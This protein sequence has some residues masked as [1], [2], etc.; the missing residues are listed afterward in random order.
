MTSAFCVTDDTELQ[1][2]PVD[3]ECEV[4]QTTPDDARLAAITL[5]PELVTQCKEDPQVLVEM[6]RGQL[7][8]VQDRMVTKLLTSGEAT[9]A[10]YAQVH[11]RL[12]KNA[13]VEPKQF[14]GSGAGFSIVLNVGPQPSKTEAATIDVTPTSIGRGDAAPELR[15]GT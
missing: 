2:L 7:A 10:Q 5:P 4:Q 14:G 8:I 15:T 11:E 3:D 12:S 6:T 13:G 1:L 9:L